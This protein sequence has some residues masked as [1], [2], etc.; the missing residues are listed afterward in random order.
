[1]IRAASR[2]AT[3][4]AQAASANDR[5]IATET[6]AIHAEK[7]FKQVAEAIRAQLIGLNNNIKCRARA[8]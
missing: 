1:M 7:A 6:R 8:A 5:A 2:I 4:E 3:A